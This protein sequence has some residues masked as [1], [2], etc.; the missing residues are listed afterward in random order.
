M[1]NVDLFF[2]F[3]LRIGTGVLN[4]GMIPVYG[5]RIRMPRRPAGGHGLT[6]LNSAF[7]LTQA[8]GILIVLSHELLVNLISFTFFN[9]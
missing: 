1:K 5:L 7:N 2:L 6:S 8:S 4:W 9:G 3:P